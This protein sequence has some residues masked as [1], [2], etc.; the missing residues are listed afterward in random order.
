MVNDKSAS[1]SVCVSTTINISLRILK[2]GYLQ[3]LTRA[4]MFHFSYL[5]G[6]QC[7]DMNLSKL[8]SSNGDVC[9]FSFFFLGWG[10]GKHF[11]QCCTKTRMG[12]QTGTKIDKSL[13]LEGGFGCWGIPE[14]QM[15]TFRG[16]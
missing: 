13:K 3:V 14:Y 2:L 16:T 5:L 6:F 8:I 7:F 10:D 11:Y 9:I 15:G 4:D 1:T 12:T